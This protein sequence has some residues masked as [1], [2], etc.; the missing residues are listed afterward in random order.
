MTDEKDL[1]MRCPKLDWKQSE[2]RLRTDILEEFR[3]FD[4]W[5]MQEVAKHEM[6][7]DIDMQQAIETEKEIWL[8]VFQLYTDTSMQVSSILEDK[9]LSANQTKNEKIW[10]ISIIW[11]MS[12]AEMQ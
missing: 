4:V 3:R 6:I 1:C 8:R 5:A 7:N 11:E 12:V 2:R 10:T 9:L